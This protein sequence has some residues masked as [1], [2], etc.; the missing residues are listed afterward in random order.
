M[1]KGCCNGCKDV[2][3]TPMMTRDK[4]L[5]KFA[6]RR[7]K[8]R[9]LR[10]EDPKF[11]TLRRLGKRFKVTP[12]RARQLLEVKPNGPIPSKEPK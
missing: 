4:Y 9:A 7:A 6:I 8:I 11:W 3:N 5:E 2:H 10:D 12:E 1:L